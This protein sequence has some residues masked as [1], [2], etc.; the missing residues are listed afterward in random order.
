[1]SVGFHGSIVKVG[2]Q[3]SVLCATTS[4]VTLVTEV[5]SYGGVALF[6]AFAAAC[7]VAGV[8]DITTTGDLNGIAGVNS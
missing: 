7:S 4:L 2:S 3:G 8:A 5:T 6:A 1:M